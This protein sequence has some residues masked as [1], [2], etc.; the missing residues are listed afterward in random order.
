MSFRCMPQVYQSSAVWQAGL[1]DFSESPL[2][3]GKSKVFAQLDACVERE[4]GGSDLPLCRPIASFG[5]RLWHRHPRNRL[6]HNVTIRAA[7]LQPHVA[8]Q[9]VG[10]GANSKPLEPVVLVAGV[11]PLISTVGDN[12]LIA[13]LGQSLLN[14]DPLRHTTLSFRYTVF[15]RSS[16]PRSVAAR[17]TPSGPT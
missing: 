17:A 4:M 11:R 2:F 12:D 8:F 5:R 9:P 1:K 13:S 10:C 15:V 3:I 16:N 6:L 14:A 7:K